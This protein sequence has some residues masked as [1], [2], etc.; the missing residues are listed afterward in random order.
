M[1]R[2]RADQSTQEFP[3]A[4][5]DTVEIP[6]AEMRR[7]VWPVPVIFGSA[8]ALAVGIPWFLMATQV[9]TTL[10]YPVFV[11]TAVESVEPLKASP[12]P[13]A[14][15]KA[16]KTVRAKPAPARTVYVPTYVYRTRTAAPKPRPTVTVTATRTIKACIE[17]DI[18]GLILG[19]ISCP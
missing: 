18:E 19:E 14:T 2:H 6:A 5:H 3:A 16:T 11:P 1:G 13:T 8:L 15:V 4:L 17:V 12:L 9:D 7:H 10:S